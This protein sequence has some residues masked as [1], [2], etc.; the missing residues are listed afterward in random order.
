MMS[1]KYSLLE[2]SHFR[3]DGGA[4]YGIIPRPLW[5][6]K[7]PPDEENRIDLALRLLLIEEGPYKVLVDTGIG[8]YRDDKFN[9]L[10]DVRSESSPLEKCLT[11][12]SLK[13][14]EITDIIISHLHFDHVGGLGKKGEQG[15]LEPLFPKARLHLQQKHY[16]Y[17]LKA[18]PR[19]RGSFKTEEFVP[20]IDHYRQQGLLVFHREESGELIKEINLK[21]KTSM[22]HTPWMLHP[23]NKDLFYLADLVPT[24]HHIH[25]PWVMG[26][27]IE[28]GKTTLYKEEILRFIAEKN[29]VAI[30]EHD[31]D[32]WGAKI[33]Y[34]ENKFVAREK[35]KALAQKSY[36][37]E[38]LS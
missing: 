7:S 8:D 12:L 22:G 15:V 31:P 24:S 33:E 6:K 28:A 27:D 32:V 16:E 21:Y 9:H 10:F 25:I 18:T 5:S 2:P 30:F 35:F 11:T 29:L 14:D 19:D 3:L 34:K 37:L 36:P 4:M 38:L 23:Y 13:V 26:Y 1:G 17:A 20:L